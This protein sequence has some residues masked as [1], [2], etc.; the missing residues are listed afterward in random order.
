MLLAW[1]RLH[2]DG[3]GLAGGAAL[4]LLGLAA[5]LAPWLA[6]HD[7]DAVQVAARSQ[8]PSPVH[9]LG[10]DELGRDVLS[11]LLWGGR[12]SLTVG[13][14]AVGISVT[15]G[16]V[17][18]AVAGYHGGRTDRAIM[19]VCDLFLAVPFLPLALTLSALLEPSI[20]HTMAIIGAL[21][22]TGTA[23]LVRAELLALKQREFILAARAAGAPDHRILW[24]HL[25]PNALA[26]VLVAA[27]LGVAGAVSAEASLSFLGLGVPQPVPSWGNMLAGALSAAVLLRAPWI[28]VPPGLCI[29]VAVVSINLVGDSLRDVFDP[30][31]RA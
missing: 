9:P 12:V 26:P 31:L 1:R 10:T 21:G 8:A 13:L 11:R 17:A 18:G 14:A 19:Q 22:W 4:V 3:R 16:V 23:R 30:R 27:T 7:R 20:Y 29:L 28:W 15:V 2:R 25:V 5:W 24:L 6:P